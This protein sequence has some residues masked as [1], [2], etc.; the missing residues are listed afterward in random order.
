MKK[1]ALVLL[2][3]LKSV[4]NGIQAELG[5]YINNLRKE[6]RILAE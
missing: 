1:K 5:S 3:S 2:E 6:N 4:I